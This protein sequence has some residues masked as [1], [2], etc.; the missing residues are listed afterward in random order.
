MT[1]QILYYR[2]RSY[3][4]NKRLKQRSVG[5]GTNRAPNMAHKMMN[6][7]IEL[8]IQSLIYNLDLVW[9]FMKDLSKVMSKIDLFPLLKLWWDILSQVL[10]IN[11]ILENDDS[12]FIIDSFVP[13]ECGLG[14]PGVE[15]VEYKMR[16]STKLCCY[17]VRYKKPQAQEKV[18]VQT[19]VKR[20]YQ[21]QTP[22]QVQTEV[23]SKEPWR[24]SLF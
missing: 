11:V 20:K 17:P 10:V 2:Q 18:Q 6:D 8:K 12:I 14:V 3:Q 24:W 4:M 9:H 21:T 16:P 19:Q 22:T 23:P 1:S 7:W 13:P 15:E 5:C